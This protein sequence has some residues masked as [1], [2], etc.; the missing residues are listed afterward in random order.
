[1]PVIVP[2][3]PYSPNGPQPTK[4]KA[5]IVVIALA[6]V[7]MIA[8]VGFY[9]ASA[10]NSNGSLTSRVVSSLFTRGTRIDV[11]QPT[12]VRRIQQLQRLETVVYTMDK[13]VTGER[14][15]PMLPDFLAGDRLLLLV[16]GEV[17]AG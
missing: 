10:P 3:P 13:I 4:G 2:R 9:F 11:S 16:H 7:F 8:G 6:L 17:V 5:V 14:E 1:M 15:N 12:V